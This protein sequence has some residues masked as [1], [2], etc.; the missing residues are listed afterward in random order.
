[1]NLEDLAGRI[2]AQVVAKGRAADIGVDR[3]YAGDRMS[4]L[5]NQA[6]DR[7]L[8]VT[9]L[10]SALLIRV[11]ELMDVPGVCLVGGQHVTPELLE[12]ARLHGLFVMVSP[13]DMFETCGRLYDCWTEAKRTGQ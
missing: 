1:M 13:H 9:N 11:A 12:A 5:L 6:S 8:I 2:G 3:I 7:T 4:D 10:A